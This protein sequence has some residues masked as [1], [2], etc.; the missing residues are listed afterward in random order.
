MSQIVRL[1]WVH[2]PSLCFVQQLAGDPDEH[3]V[4]KRRLEARLGE[5][6]E[7]LCDGETVVLPEVIQ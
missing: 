7:H 1:L 6:V 4:G 5:L 2:S 3:A